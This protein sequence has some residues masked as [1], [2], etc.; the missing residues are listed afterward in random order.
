MKNPGWANNRGSPPY[1]SRH[2]SYQIPLSPNAPAAMILKPKTA[3]GDEDG[4]LSSLGRC[5]D[6]Y[7]SWRVPTSIGT[8]ILLR[9]RGFGAYFCRR[10]KPHCG[11][12]LTTTTRHGFAFQ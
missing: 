2:S 3:C 8:D 1:I 10:Q 7:V 6:L 5:S 4:S 9:R 12:A 11:G